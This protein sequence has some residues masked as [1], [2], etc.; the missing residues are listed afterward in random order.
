MKKIILFCMLFCVGLCACNRIPSEEQSVS[1][2]VQES[3]MAESVLPESIPAESS[4]AVPVSFME[5]YTA[6]VAENNVKR[7]ALIYL[8]E[9]EIPELLILRDGKYELY[10][11]TGFGIKEIGMPS[12][13]IEADAY[14][15]RHQ[16]EDSYDS[17]F[18][19]FEYA[20]YKGL[21][22]VHC[23]EGRER[24]DYYLKYEDG[25]L[26]VEL[27][28]KT[29]NY[30]WSTYDGEKEIPNEEFLSLLSELG[31]DQLK[32][33]AYLYEN[34]AD[35]YDNMDAVW[36]SQKLLRDFENGVIEAVDHV[37]DIK[38]I[39]E[40]GFVMISYM[41]YVSDITA[42]ED[43]WLE[44][45]YIDFDND[46]EEEMI[47]HG[48]AGACL[49]FD[50]IGDTVY[51]V[52]HTG[53]TANVASVAEIDG[54]RVVEATDLLHG[55]RK[56]YRIMQYDSC[57]W[58]VDWFRLYAEYNGSNYTSEDLFEYRDQP[59]TME[60]FEEIVDSIHRL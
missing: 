37:E 39:P 57:C 23:G 60:E 50:V 34:V 31:Y 4:A 21:M 35:A 56:F 7:E 5:E 2:E 52:L 13:S 43:W 27:A 51:K 10:T 32:P 3:E 24:S 54:K 12:D 47:I 9:D 8:D 41:D 15:P 19:W 17:V 38:D 25:A 45:E 14:G 30:M 53:G 58:L 28:A 36:D 33:C 26:G 49:F 18:L 42:G 6:F 46:G 48:Y 11:S 1:S 55:G 29:E 22:R 16:I 44:T 59:V 20:P 40:D